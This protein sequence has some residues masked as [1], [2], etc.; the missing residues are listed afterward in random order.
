MLRVVL[1]GGPGAGKSRLLECLRSQGFA[2]VGETARSVIQ[3]R[4]NNGL[5]PRPGPREFADEILRRD[6]NNYKTLTTPEC[7]FFDRGILDALCMLDAVSPL[8][9][10][11]LEA[12]ISRYPYHKQA[13]FLP[14][15]K[16]IYT[17]DA[18]R[19]QTFDESVAVYET[20]HKW[21]RRCGYE[22]LEVP[23]VSVRERCAYVLRALGFVGS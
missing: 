11:E 2:V 5:S 13:L 16:E 9:S 21:Y 18:E 14:P 22:I 12:W 17:N 15:W 19:D 6:I 7:L 3:E 4:R 20:L 8:S 23:K 1:T 10:Q